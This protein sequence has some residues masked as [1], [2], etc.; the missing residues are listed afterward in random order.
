MA[1]RSFIYAFWLWP[2]GKLSDHRAAGLRPS[3]VAILS[4]ILGTRRIHNGNAEMKVET[5]AE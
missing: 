2:G 5:K 4:S 1:F 3:H